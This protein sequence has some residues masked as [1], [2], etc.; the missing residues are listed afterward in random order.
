MA[1]DDSPLV[2]HQEVGVVALLK[3]ILG[4]PLVGELVVE[5]VY[6]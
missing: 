5:V 4:N 2:P 1:V 6:V 3:G